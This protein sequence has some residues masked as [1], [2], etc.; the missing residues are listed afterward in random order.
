[1]GRWLWVPA[2]DAQLR[3]WAGTTLE[4]VDTS[5]RSRGSIRPRF[6]YISPAKNRGRREDRVRAAPAVSCAICAQEHAHEHTGSAEASGLPC[7][8]VLRLTSRSPR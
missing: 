8:M 2:P 4:I 6:A 3:I 1:M 7:A 5:S